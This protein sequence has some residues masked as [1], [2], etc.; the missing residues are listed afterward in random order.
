MFGG[1][2]TKPLTAQMATLNSTMT[3]FQPHFHKFPPIRW[4]SPKCKKPP[5]SN[6]IQA[7]MTHVFIQKSVG[8]SLE[9][10]GQWV[11]C[12]QSWGWAGWAGVN[13]QEANE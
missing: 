8:G 11:F 3:L 5:H 2:H 1:G 4:E 12:S 9:Q 7:H 10:D 6:L 13:S